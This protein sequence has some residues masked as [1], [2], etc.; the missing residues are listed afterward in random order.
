MCITICWFT[1]I[2]PCSTIYCSY[3]YIYVALSTGSHG[4][5]RVALSTGLKFHGLNHQSK[6]HCL[7]ITF[8]YIFH[9][10]PHF[11]K[12]LFQSQFLFDFDEIFTNKSENVWSFLCLFLWSLFENVSNSLNNFNVWFCSPGVNV[13]TAHVPMIIYV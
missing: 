11:F 6:W 5:T 10:K 7:D 8:C 9:I 2:Y 3:G 1:W 12:T 4:Y 13:W